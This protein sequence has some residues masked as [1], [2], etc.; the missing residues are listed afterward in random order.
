MTMP[1]R[2]ARRRRAVGWGLA[3]VVLA[4]LL[5]GAASGVAGAQQPAGQRPQ[6]EFVPV[7]DLGPQEQ[8]A[9]APL[10]VAAYVFVWLALLVYL[11]SIWRRLGKVERELSALS[12]RLGEKG[13]SGRPA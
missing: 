11:W 4:V 12:R 2:F 13:G 9:A 8:L 7:K 1:R 5:A 6:D 10:L 3:W